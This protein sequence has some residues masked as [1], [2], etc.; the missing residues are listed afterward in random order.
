MTKKFPTAFAERNKIAIAVI[1]MTVMAVLCLLTFNAASLP[2]IGGGKVYSAQFAEA[3]GLKEGNEVRVAG[4]KVGKVTDISLEGAVVTVKFRAKVDE[5]GDQTTASVKVK[6]MLGQKFL[7]VDP[8]GSKQL[9][10]PIPL[11]RTTTPYDVNEAFSDLSDSIE[12]ID[13]GQLEASFT[14]L[15]DAFRNTPESVRTMVTGL[16]DLS[17]TISSR[18]DELTK[19]FDA[20]SDVSKTLKDRNAEFAKIITDGSSLLDELEQRRDTVAK[21]LDGTAR[22]GVQLQGLV[23]DNEKA[24]RPALAKLDDVSRILQDNQDNLDA[25]L[26]RLGPYYRV[27]SSALGN[28]KWTDAYVCGLF[29]ADKRPLLEN[30]V[31]RNCAPAKGGGR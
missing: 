25:A 13:T 28:G 22:L 15:S 20:T 14:A 9:D 11:A 10:G 2:I 19:L 26:K 16:T 4:V 1:G 30:D 3:G 5:L 8:L 23:K 21:M 12:T 6:T 17:R 24:L 27:L 18:D 7:A 31:A 29:D